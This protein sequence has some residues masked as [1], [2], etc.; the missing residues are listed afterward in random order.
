MTYRSYPALKKYILTVFADEIRSSTPINHVT[1]SRAVEGYLGISYQPA[2][3]AIISLWRGYRE[4]MR[5]LYRLVEK[6]AP[7]EIDP[8]FR[9]ARGEE[10]WPVSTNS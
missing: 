10:Q 4:E 9:E 2:K 1:L 8:C 7:T 3:T 5:P 6:W